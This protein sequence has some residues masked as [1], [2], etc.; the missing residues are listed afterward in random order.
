MSKKIYVID[1]NSLLFRAYYATAYGD[2]S[3]IMRTKN[4][5]PTNAIFAFAN[6]L[7]KI[8]SSFK[9]DESIFIGFDTDKETFRKAEFADYKANRKPAPADLIPQF[10]ISRELVNALGIVY[11]E[12]HGIE[13][14]DI[15]GTVATLASQEGY[16]VTI[17]TSDKDYLQL[18]D[19]N[20][21]V[22]LLKTGL[23]NMQVLDEQGLKEAYGLSPS[24]IVDFKGLRGD[25]S[26]NYPGIPGIGEK[27]AFKLLEEYGTFEK[28]IEASPSIKGKLG[29][30]IRANV[31]L[32]RES[33]RLATIKRDVKLPFSIADLLYHG[34]DFGSV[35]DFATKY[36]FKQLL[37]RL[38]LSLKKGSSLAISITP[39]VIQDS[40]NLAFP[41]F[42]GLALDIDYGNY[43][44]EDPKGIA[45]CLGDKVY[46]EKKEDFL[47]DQKLNDILASNDIKKIVYDGKATIY[48]L[49]KLHLS[50]SGIDNDVLLAAYLLDSSVS[51]NPELVY[52]SFG[53]DISDEKTEEPLSLLTG[54]EPSEIGKTAKM[55]Y[56]AFNLLDKINGSLRSVDAYS[57]YKDIE[58]PL[59]SV[60]A[61]MEIDGFPLHQEKLKEY[62]A[63][64]TKKKKAL[65]N[66]IYALAGEEF[67]LNS[68]R[69]VGEILFDK[70]GLKGPKDKSTSVDVLMGLQ[71][72]SPI[73][74]PLLEYR[75]YAKLLSTYV[76]GL[77]PHIKEDG[78]IHSYFNQAQTST[79][80]LSSS[81]PNLQNISARDEEGKLI[82][83]AFY[84]DDDSIRLLSLD[85]GQ[86]ELRILAAL[87]H[88]QA[89]IDVFNAGHDVHSETAKKIFHS[90][91]VTPLMRRK[92]KAVNFAII[93][94]TTVYGLASQIGTSTSEA[95]SIIH[96]FYAA[97]PEVG[98][99]LNQ[100]IVDATTKGYV[101]T[102]FGRRR[103]LREVNDPNYA[104]REAARRAAL[105]APVQGSAA[106]LIKIAMVKID[107]FL[108]EGHYQTK[109]VLQIHDELIFKVPVS[110]LDEMKSSL[111]DIMTSAVNL[112]VKLTVEEGIGKNWYEAKD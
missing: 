11:Y 15:C 22:S 17:Y 48:A 69:Q 108:H 61:S 104:K 23:S 95:S 102:M 79:G 26:D 90:D 74:A 53:Y 82:R 62:G 96:S 66:D 60:L 3:S 51:S 9:G 64:F 27:T 4:G 25:S 38:P 80:R 8:L 42:I 12:Q 91:E 46:Y 81:C 67:N 21:K 55:A 112:P 10:P 1:G 93:Y 54:E 58:M 70:L 57:L 32:G 30:N 47:K 71:D 13:A 56:Y 87:S 36:E 20:T 86:I 6:M 85:Y 105:N 65:E 5:T 92:A 106:D 29:E 34:Y 14:D 16:E 19:K 40:K 78:K 35:N 77:V 59:M 68:P 45:F 111:A 52:S 44:D 37:S 100:I 103:Y 94:G 39:E 83:N 24:Q 50:I 107:K 63:I 72:E 31:E 89:Y 2:S 88:C 28:I 76:D 7:S 18:I 99:F 73:I 84:Y 110:E 101:T 75:K 49:N 43:H 33:Y 97:Y 98:A 41:S 109:L